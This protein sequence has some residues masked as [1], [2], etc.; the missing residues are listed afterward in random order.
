MILLAAESEISVEYLVASHNLDRRLPMNTR[1]LSWEELR[2]RKT[3][4]PTASIPDEF[5]ELLSERRTPVRKT[6]FLERS[7]SDERGAPEALTLEAYRPPWLATSFRPKRARV[8]K[9]PTVLHHDQRLEPTI[10]YPPGLASR[11]S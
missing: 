8:P 9:P 4:G 10:T 11:D 2:R 7:V 1:P 3:D 5:R 6:R